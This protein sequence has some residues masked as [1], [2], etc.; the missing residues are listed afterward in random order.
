MAAAY[1]TVRHNWRFDQIVPG[2]LRICWDHLG[3]SWVEQIVNLVLTILQKHFYTN[4]S[5]QDVINPF[6]KPND[7][8]PTRIQTE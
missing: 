5:K 7:W 1:E 2:S 4:K 8:N 6:G 3:L